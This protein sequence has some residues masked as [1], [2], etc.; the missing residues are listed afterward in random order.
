VR[1][2][3]ANLLEQNIHAREIMAE[4]AKT[5]L[6]LIPSTPGV[7]PPEPSEKLGVHGRL[8]WDRIHSEWSVTD[9]AG[10]EMLML[11][12]LARDRAANCRETIDRDGAVTETKHGP[13]EHCLLRAELAA[14][15]FCAK[16]LRALGLN[17]EPLRSSGGRPPKLYGGL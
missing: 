13:R 14:M 4:K 6:H 3:N 11:A 7:A 15:A 17:S 2:K 5:G 12:C 16:T 8:L 9:S 1:G 10:I